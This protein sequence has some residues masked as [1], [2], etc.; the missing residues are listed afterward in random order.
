VE[1]EVDDSLGKK[2]EKQ[3][4]ELGL[5]LREIVE[6]TLREFLAD[7]EA[8]ACPELDKALKRLAWRG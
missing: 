3:A 1:I 6:W 5:S 8:L 2:A 7:V 4:N